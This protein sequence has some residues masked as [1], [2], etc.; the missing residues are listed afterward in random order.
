[1]RTLKI[2]YVVFQMNKIKDTKFLSDNKKKM[3][4]LFSKIQYFS[5]RPS[6]FKP[7]RA[8]LEYLADM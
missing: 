3:G 5:T 6:G 8:G 1:M 7:V 4:S 2:A